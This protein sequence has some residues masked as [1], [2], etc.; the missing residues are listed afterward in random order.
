MAASFIHKNM[1]LQPDNYRGEKT[2]FATLCFHNRRRIGSNPR[3]AS[4][5]V[6]CLRKIAAQKSFLVHAYCVMPDHL[7]LLIQGAAPDS[8]LMA[9]VELFKQDTGFRF[10]AK[11]GRQLWQFKYY[12][13]ILRKVEAANR[14]AGYIWMN[15]VRQG[16]CAVPQDYPFSGSFTEFGATMLQQ[17]S[18]ESWTPPWKKKDS[19]VK[20]PKV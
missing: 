19:A 14:I 5:L 9:F 7:H 20:E 8:D 15:P 12:D 6:D 10:L 17:S 18:P 4:W 16:I 2:Y 13:R 1:R 3:V 11:T